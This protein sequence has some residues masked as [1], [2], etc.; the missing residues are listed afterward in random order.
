M[1]AGWKDFVILEDSGAGMS[2]KCDSYLT[3][4]LALRFICTTCFHTVAC[5]GGWVAVAGEGSVITSGLG[6]WGEGGGE[7]GGG[8]GGISISCRK[9][10]WGEQISCNIHSA[11]TGGEGEA[12]EQMLIISHGYILT[13]T[14]LSHTSLITVH[15]TH[16]LPYLPHHCPLQY[17]VFGDLVPIAVFTGTRC[18]AHCPR[19]RKL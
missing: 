6:G 14:Q 18:H 5:R 7:G 15:T 8:E 4:S 13:N 11:S 19:G 3:C 2:I 12:Y 9:F 10:P 17:T 1:P 16:C